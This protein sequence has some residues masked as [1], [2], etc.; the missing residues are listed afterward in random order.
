MLQFLVAEQAVSKAGCTLKKVSFPFTVVNKDAL[1]FR[2]PPDVEQ[3]CCSQCLATMQS[4][5]PKEMRDEWAGQPKEEDK[6]CL[7]S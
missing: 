6:P 7:V 3:P 5:S 1:H 4:G 2:A